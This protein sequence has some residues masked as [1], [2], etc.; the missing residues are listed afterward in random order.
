M[1]PMKSI[2]FTKD[3]VYFSNRHF[4]NGK[5]YC[6]WISRAFRYGSKARFTRG[7]DRLEKQALVERR[8][9]TDKRIRLICLTEKGEAI[10]ATAHPLWKEA[11]SKLVNKLGLEKTQQL[12]ALLAEVS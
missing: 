6:Q 1:S 10:F 8:P 3:A 7:I 4:D 12:L 11:Q 9:G 5:L 2:W